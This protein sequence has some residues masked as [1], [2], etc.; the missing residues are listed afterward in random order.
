M[1]RSGQKYSSFCF[2]KNCSQAGHT[3]DLHNLLRYV[4]LVTIFI[5]VFNISIIPARDQ[6]I[7]VTVFLGD[8]FR[9]QVQFANIKW[10]VDLTDK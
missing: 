1:K 8:Y 10:R 9:Y 2:P 3:N 5:V 4:V 6:N 7:F